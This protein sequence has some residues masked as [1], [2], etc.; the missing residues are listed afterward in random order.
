[1]AIA[2]MHRW[3]F[4]ASSDRPLPAEM[5]LLERSPANDPLPQT[6][7]RPRHSSYCS[8]WMAVIEDPL[9]Y[10]KQ[11]TAPFESLSLAKQFRPVMVIF[12]VPACKY[13]WCPSSMA[14]SHTNLT[15][16][17]DPRIAHRILLRFC[18][19]TKVRLCSSCRGCLAPLEPFDAEAGA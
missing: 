18:A 10:N 5:K 19:L 8:T 15:F 12:F 9:Q 11:T 13:P 2:S 4:E 16:R 17:F 1:M 6:P 14:K 7:S 3:D